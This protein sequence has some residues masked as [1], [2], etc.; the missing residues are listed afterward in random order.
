VGESRSVNKACQT[1]TY[2]TRKLQSLIVLSLHGR[3]PWSV[4]WLQTGRRACFSNTDTQRLPLNKQELL[5]FAL[6]IELLPIDSSHQVTLRAFCNQPKQ[7][8]S[9]CSYV[10]GWPRSAPRIVYFKCDSRRLHRGRPIISPLYKCNL[11]YELLVL[12]P[13]DHVVHAHGV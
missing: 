9:A 12:F 5:P 6:V 11:W 8:F 3:I 2:L 7:R 10:Y 13:H 4:V 1:N